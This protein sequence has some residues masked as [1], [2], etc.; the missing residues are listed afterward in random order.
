MFGGWEQ[1]NRNDL[2]NEHLE[3]YSENIY[4][5]TTLKLFGK[6]HDESKIFKP[7]YRLR[8]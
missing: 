1:C 5:F 3:K 7:I 2:K 6:Q 8:I 4:N